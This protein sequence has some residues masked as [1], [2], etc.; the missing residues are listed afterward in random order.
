MYYKLTQVYLKLHLSTK[1]FLSPHR[2][3]H[4]AAKALA[5]LGASPAFTRERLD[6]HLPETLQMAWSPAVPAQACGHAVGGTLL[7]RACLARAVAPEQP[8]QVV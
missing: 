4:F 5:L 2:D 6:H 8:Y 1:G 3:D 7:C